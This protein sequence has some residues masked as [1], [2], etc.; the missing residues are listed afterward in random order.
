MT[1]R[2]LIDIQ[3]GETFIASRRMTFTVNTADKEPIGFIVEPGETIKKI[4][5]AL[6]EVKG[7]WHI[8]VSANMLIDES[9]ATNWD[10]TAH[11]RNQRRKSELDAQAKKFGYGNWGEV[12]SLARLG[13]DVLRQ[14]E[15]T[16]E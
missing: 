1:K 6:I 14:K 16:N 5:P 10:Y 11:K 2:R 12:Q 13:I 4:G 3:E 7:Q 15:E 8:R 9:P